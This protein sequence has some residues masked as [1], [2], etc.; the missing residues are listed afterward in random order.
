M[1]GWNA[2]QYLKFKRERTQPSYDLAAGITVRDPARIIDIGCGPGNSTAVLAERF[3][4]AYILGADNSQDMIASAKKSH[5]ELDFMLFDAEKDFEKIS[6]RFDVVFSNACIQWVPA[7]DRLIK[8]M[9]GLL[10]PGGMLAIQVPINYDEP[11]HKIIAEVSHSAKWQG[12]F[13]VYRE[14]YTLTPGEYF[15]LLSELTDDFRMWETIYYHRMGSHQ[16]IME[17]YK[18]T[19]LRPYLEALVDDDR[20][21]FENDVYREIVKAYPVQKSGEI[22]FRFPRLFFTASKGD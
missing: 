16:D 13:S 15:D 10:A 7:H 6:Q 17:W 14:F 3:K 18:G 9:F 2:E 8:N 1:S 12:K 19:G 5:P 22:I 11:I 21:E 20:K 4:G